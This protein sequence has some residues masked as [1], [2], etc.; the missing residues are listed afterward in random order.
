MGG[1]GRKDSGERPLPGQAIRGSHVGW[2]KI[3][4]MSPGEVSLVK[5]AAKVDFPRLGE[6]G[7]LNELTRYR[8]ATKH[9]SRP[10]GSGPYPPK[11]AT[12]HFVSQ[13]NRH[14]Y[15]GASG[16]VRNRMSR[17][18]RLH[19]ESKISNASEPAVLTFRF[20]TDGGLFGSRFLG[21]RSTRCER[22][23]YVRALANV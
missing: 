2:G 11:P 15:Y 21:T 20:K 1:I 13:P 5:S 10:G 23:V 7:N 3:F 18:G 17:N 9:T 4:R 14:Y 22:R 6:I 16:G 8:D 19:F 12:R